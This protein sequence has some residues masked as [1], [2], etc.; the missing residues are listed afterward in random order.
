MIGGAEMRGSHRPVS[1]LVAVA[2]LA[3]FA[4]MPLWRWVAAPPAEE[5]YAI[6]PAAFE[7]KV[8]A[9]TAAYATGAEVKGVP[10]VRPPAG[11][12]YLLARRWEFHPVL[13][14]EAG[15]TYRLHVASSDVIHGFHSAGVDRLLAPGSAA[16][17]TITPDSA[18]SIGVQC[19]EFCGAEHNKM[20]ARILVIDGKN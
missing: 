18:G 20:T 10:V 9:M 7:A 2:A 1:A 3:L 15:K 5:R 12:V 17:L 4:A 11:D 14:L 16:V 8:D 19:S 13:E 6:E